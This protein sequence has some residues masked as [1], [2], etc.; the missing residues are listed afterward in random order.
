MYLFSQKE[1]QFLKTLFKDE[2]N[3]YKV[4]IGKFKHIP[5]QKN[6]KQIEKIIDSNTEEQMLSILKKYETKYNYK[7]LSKNGDKYDLANM[8]FHLNIDPFFYNTPFELLPKYS[9]FDLSGFSLQQ[10]LYIC[11][12]FNIDVNSFM[13]YSNS[14]IID[15]SKEITSDQRRNFIE[16]CKNMNIVL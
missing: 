11:K 3:S 13:I 5:I 9:L 6:E 4:Y 1:I 7:L 12:Q 16:I 8:I 2:L 15:F 14:K 10:I